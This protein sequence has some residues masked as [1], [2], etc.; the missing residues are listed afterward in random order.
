MLADFLAVIVYG[1]GLS[2]LLTAAMLPSATGEAQATAAVIVAVEDWG[3]ASNASSIRAMC[4]DTTSSNIG[5]L[6]GTCILS[7]QKIS[8]ELLSLQADMMLWNW[9]LVAPH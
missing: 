4:F 3:I 1:K 7:K 5:R 6:A 8:K 9:S 2:Q